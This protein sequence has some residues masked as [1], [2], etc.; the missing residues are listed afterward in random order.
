MSEDLLILNSLGLINCQN[1]NYINVVNVLNSYKMHYFPISCFQQY[2]SGT[3]LLVATA[4]TAA[5]E[6]DSVDSLYY[7]LHAI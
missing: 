5:A 7:F 2:V 3:L 6:V 1:I 4:A